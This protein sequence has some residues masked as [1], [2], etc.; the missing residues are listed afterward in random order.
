MTGKGNRV[1]DRKCG[2]YMLSMGCL[3]AIFLL[4]QKA[5]LR[6]GDR[7]YLAELDKTNKYRSY[8]QTLLLWQKVS[9]EGKH[10]C[11]YFNASESIAVYGMGDIGK[12]ICRA[13]R[14]G[15]RNLKYA[16]DKSST[17][18][19]A[20]LGIRVYLPDEVLPQADVAIISLEFAAEQ[21]APVLR[22]RGI[23][24]VVTVDEVL[25]ALLGDAG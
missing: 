11:D 1:I 5:V 7:E 14:D 20:S 4:L 16:I 24:R 25:E 23:W 13:L 19:D 8:F 21:T 10:L 3:S 15:G 2:K 22:E 9:L 12:L 17:A 18:V 6:K